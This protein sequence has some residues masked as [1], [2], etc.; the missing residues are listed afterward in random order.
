MLLLAVIATSG[1]VAVGVSFVLTAQQGASLAVTAGQACSGGAVAASPDGRA[2][3]NEAAQVRATPLPGPLPGITG[4]A[5][6]DGVD[7]R[8]IAGTGIVDGRLVLTYSDGTTET[9][10]Q[11][12]G[13]PGAQ[14]V[15]ITDSD[16]VDG[17]LVLTFSDGSTLDVGQIVGADGA[18]GADGRGVTSI[19]AVD[20]RLMVTYSD[21]TTQDVGPLP[22]GPQ[23]DAAPSV[24]SVTRTFSDGSTEVCTRTGGPDTDPVLECEV[25]AAPPQEPGEGEMGG[26]G[27]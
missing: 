10:G 20:G 16:V 3:C 26:P 17:Q 13:A 12:V 8:G 18:A 15:G 2:L 14:G 5:G 23:G 27:G 22:A 9:V 11:V 1:A 6:T 21:G 24:Q 4:P 25:T 7:G 19:A